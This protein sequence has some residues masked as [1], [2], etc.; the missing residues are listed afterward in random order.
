MLLQDTIIRLENECGCL[1]CCAFTDFD[2]GEV[3]ALYNE[4]EVLKSASTIK[5]P[6]MLT[7]LQDVEAGKLAMTDMIP[8]TAKQFTGD[9]KT[10]TENDHEATLELLL[11]TMITDSDN[12]ATNA[13]IDLMGMDR[14]NAVIRSLGL[15]DTVLRRHM[16]DFG[17]AQR[18]SENT[19]SARD[20]LRLYTLI[21]RRELISDAVCEMALP[22]LL[23]QHDDSLIRF[24]MPQ[25]K[26]AHKTGGLPGIVHDTG[27]LYGENRTLGYAV[28]TFA[29]DDV[30]GEHFIQKLSAEVK[31]LL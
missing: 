27:I 10:F 16:L 9:S 11:E 3:L 18:G 14:I 29:D 30:K 12:T 8:I 20:M 26:T 13:L 4:C 28:L 25:Q 24:A 5:T 17:A 31:K 19:T 6:I 1:A 2:S 22:I 23:R 15:Y 21:H 7:V